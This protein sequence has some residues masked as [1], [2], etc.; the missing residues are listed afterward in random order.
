MQNK[1]TQNGRVM[2][3]RE[4]QQRAHPHKTAKTRCP[5]SSRRSSSA[6]PKGAPALGFAQAQHGVPGQNQHDRDHQQG[7]SPGAYRLHQQHIEQLSCHR[8]AQ[9]DARLCKRFWAG[10]R[11]TSAETH[12]AIAQAPTAKTRANKGSIAIVHH[13]EQGIPPADSASLARAPAG[14]PARTAWGLSRRCGE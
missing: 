12:R 1:A 3:I 10:G 6:W 2:V 9:I 5:E 7:I 13:I 14:S 4:R 8:T 11:L